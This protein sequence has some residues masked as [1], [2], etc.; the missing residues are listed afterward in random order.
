[1]WMTGDSTVCTTMGLAHSYTMSWADRT[2]VDVKLVYS[3]LDE[4]CHYT[5]K[6]SRVRRPGNQFTGGHTKLLIDRIYH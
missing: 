6:A 2:L 4:Y 3:S 1:M 5:A